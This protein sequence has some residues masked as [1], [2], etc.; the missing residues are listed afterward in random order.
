MI[1]IVLSAIISAMVALLGTPLLIKVLTRR[2]L[3][4]AIRESADGIVY[5]EHSGKK[6]TPS[7]GGLAIVIAVLLGYGLSHL[8]R[9][10]PPTP[11]GLL[12][13]VAQRW[14]PGAHEAARPGRG[15][16]E[17]RLAGDPVPRRCGADPG[18]PGDLAGP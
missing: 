6:G 3:A 13:Q 9:W 5:P 14:R 15:R 1:Q 16:P 2:N 11:S 18:L 7:M 10:T 4:Q 8:I 12:A 17:L